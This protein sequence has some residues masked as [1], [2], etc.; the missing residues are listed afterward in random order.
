MVAVKRLC[1]FLRGMPRIVQRIDFGDYAPTIVRAYVDSDWAGC[2]RTRKSTSGGVLMLGTTAV[3]GWST[4][5]AVIALSSGEAE[6]YA[7]LKGAS[8][9]LGYQSML[10]DV[11]MDTTVT[12][13]SDS[14]AARGIIH[15]IWAWEVAPPGNR[16]LVVTGSG[17]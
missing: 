17:G 7:A 5:Q 15:R 14:S 9:A 4:N 10:R 16:I 8:S 3:R 12:L 2:R 1:R 13:Y 6:Y 11:G